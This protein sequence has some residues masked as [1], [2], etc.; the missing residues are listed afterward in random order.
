MVTVNR[1]NYV[2]RDENKKMTIGQRAKSARER[3]G[4]SQTYVAERIGIKQPTL[5]AL[6]SGD[7]A[8]S[9]YTASLASVLQVNALWLETGRGPEF[10]E[11]PDDGP[12]FDALIEIIQY[13]KLSNS[14]GRATILDAAKFAS[15]GK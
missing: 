2:V 14:V 11:P 15:K 4:L 6:E 3:L 5:S 13:Y 10:P 1:Y 12:I 9:I 7:S 8:G